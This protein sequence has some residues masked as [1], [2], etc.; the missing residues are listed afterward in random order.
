MDID[1]LNNVAAYMTKECS[2]SGLSPGDEIWV[3][4]DACHDCS[5]YD[6]HCQIG[7]TKKGKKYLEKT[8]VVKVTFTIGSGTLPSCTFRDEEGESFAPKDVHVSVFTNKEEALE[9]L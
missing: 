2:K 5:E 1:M 3:I 9:A 7:C 6:D 8:H 4:R